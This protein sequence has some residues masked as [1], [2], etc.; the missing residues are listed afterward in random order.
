MR[1]KLADLA[2]NRNLDRLPNP[3]PKDHARLERYEQ[4]TTRL[5]AALAA[6]TK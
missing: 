6:G 1:V 5:T 4:A 3:T 2:D